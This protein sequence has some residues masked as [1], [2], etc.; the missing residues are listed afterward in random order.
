M[1]QDSKAPPGLLGMPMGARQTP[2]EAILVSERHSVNLMG[3]DREGRQRDTEPARPNT[4]QLLRAQ[5]GTRF[6]QMLILLR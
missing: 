2:R 5:I 6:G 4:R 1:G 3:P